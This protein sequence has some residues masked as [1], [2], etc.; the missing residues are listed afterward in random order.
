METDEILK[1]VIDGRLD[2]SE[3]KTFE[4][5]SDKTQRRVIA[6]EIDLDE[7]LDLD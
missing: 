1:L 5:L 6:G 4:K 7:A 3:V 2:P